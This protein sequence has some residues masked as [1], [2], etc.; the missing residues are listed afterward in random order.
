M[1][2]LP[3]RVLSAISAAAAEQAVDP[4]WLKVPAPELVL[5]VR[6]EGVKPSAR[7]DAG[8]FVLMVI[9]E[10]THKGFTVHVSREYLAQE[11]AYYEKFADEER[12]PAI[13]KAVLAGL[14]KA[15]ETGAFDWDIFRKIAA[16]ED[17]P[18]ATYDYFP[19]LSPPAT[20]SRVRLESTNSAKLPTLRVVTRWDGKTA[21]GR[22]AI[23]GRETAGARFREWKGI[24]ES[25][26]RTEWRFAAALRLSASNETK[27]EKFYLWEPWVAQAVNYHPVGITSAKVLG[28]LRRGLD[29]TWDKP[30]EKKGRKAKGV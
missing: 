15:E 13:S 1:K 10:L 25:G 28:D 22:A 24:A 29:F 11:I 5:N 21:R 17:D 9:R 8:E 7:R 20:A 30:A 19:W 14:T 12:Y 27:F 4:G 2:F 6:H 3:V 18:I 23:A 26:E 16:P